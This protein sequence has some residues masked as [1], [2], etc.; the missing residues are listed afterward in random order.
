MHTV[1]AAICSLAKISITATVCVSL[2]TWDLSVCL[3]DIIV[4][5]EETVCAITYF[6]GFSDE[7][8]LV[9]NLPLSQEMNCSR[10]GAP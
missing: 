1:V 7:Y 6:V 2:A 10:H 9:F 4:L 5:S 3:D 8:R